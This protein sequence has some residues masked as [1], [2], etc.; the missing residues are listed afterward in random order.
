MCVY[1]AA[2]FGYWLFSPYSLSLVIWYYFISRNSR[3]MYTALGIPLRSSPVE[4]WL[5]TWFRKE[6]R[7]RSFRRTVPRRPTYPDLF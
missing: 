4:L 1:A 6:H 7:P 2:L 3:L 5:W